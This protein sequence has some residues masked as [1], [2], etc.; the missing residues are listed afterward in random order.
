LAFHHRDVRMMIAIIRA[1]VGCVD[2]DINDKA[3]PHQRSHEILD[4]P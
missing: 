2:R 3:A 4:E 1:A